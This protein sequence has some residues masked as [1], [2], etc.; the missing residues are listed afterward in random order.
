V[1]TDSV[2]DEANAWYNSNLGLNLSEQQLLSCSSAGTCASGY[3]NEALDF[4][5]ATGLVSESCLPYTASDTVPCSNMC[6]NPTYWKISSWSW[7]PMDTA[8]DVH[9]LDIQIGLLAYGPFADYMAIYSDF[10]NY[11]SGIYYPTSGATQEGGHFVVAVGFGFAAPPP[12]LNSGSDSVLYISMKNSWGTSWGESGFFNIYPGVANDNQWMEGINA[13]APPTAHNAI[14]QDLD[15]AGHCYWGLGPK[16]GSGCPSTCASSTEYCSYNGS[17][18]PPVV[19]LTSASLIQPWT[20]VTVTPASSS[21]ATTQSLP[22]TV[23]VSGAA[24]SPTPTGS[25]TLTSGSYISAATILSSGSAIITIPAGSLALGSDTLS[26]SYTPDSS[27]SS[28]YGASTGAAAVT[29][30]G[31]VTKLPQTITFTPIT[32]NEYALTQLTLSAAASSGLPVTF[33]STKTSIC[34]VSGNKLALLMRGT[35]IVHAT[36]AGNSSYASATTAQS[37]AVLFAPQTASF[38]P[39]T[40]KQYAL[41][42][43]TLNATASSGLPVTFSSTTPTIC[44][45]S[46]ATLTMPLLGTCI[47]H[48]TQAGNSVYASRTVA[49]SFA[50]W[51][52]IQ[53]ISFSPVAGTQHALTSQTL[54]A[55]SNVGLPVTFSSTTAAVCTV[56]GSKL[57]LLTAGTCVLHA[58]QAGNTV[59]APATIGQS[60]PVSKAVQT[61][62]FTPI[63]GKQYPLTQLTLSA[64]ASSGLAVTF[65]STATTVC[66]VAGGKLSLLTAGTCVL[67]ANQAGNTVYAPATAAQSFAVS[68]LPQTIIFPAVG[69]QTVGA[70]ATLAATATSGL[71]ISYTSTTTAVCTVS[72]STAAMVFAGTCV[73][74]AAQAG[75]SIY[76]SA[77]T[78]QSFAVKAAN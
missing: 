33:S 40:G 50:V 59:Y 42:Q 61:V 34:S 22:V 8:G 26:A 21:I 25:V 18:Q 70:N 24:G 20:T 36:Q 17:A 31:T 35:C 41:T 32:G 45:V 3:A 27:S 48:A 76:A 53:T 7:L 9:D 5:Q 39:V 1:T 13:P 63:T 72:G 49:Q 29:V 77:T 10:Y 23:T 28:I 15:G 65:S 14:C 69:S 73:L 74:H 52:A 51:G 47:V 44:S 55:T 78:A 64:T 62:S 4:V 46:G 38:T 2:Q 12:A 75:S 37:F 58:N 16:P 56:S 19:C 67:H 54:S 11:S 43:L 57:S 30:T 68:L 71:P 60:F 6:G 66:S